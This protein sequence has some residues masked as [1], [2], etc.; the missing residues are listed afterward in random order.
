VTNAR[1]GSVQVTRRNGVRV[2]SPGDLDLG[3]PA[4][5]GSDSFAEALRFTGIRYIALNPGASYRG[6]HDSLVN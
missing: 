4:A 2:D 3:Q 5:W 1:S 6:L